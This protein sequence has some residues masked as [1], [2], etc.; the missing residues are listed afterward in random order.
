[1]LAN[2]SLNLQKI[3]TVKHSL[4]MPVFNAIQD[5]FIRNRIGTVRGLTLSARQVIWWM[6]IVWVVIKAIV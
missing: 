2:A 1:M 3:Q 6:G 4:E 5:F